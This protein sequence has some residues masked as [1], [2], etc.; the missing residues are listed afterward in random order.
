MNTPFNA[1]TAAELAL[2]TLLTALS[3]G[4]NRNLKAGN[5]LLAKAHADE[6]TIVIT[7]LDGFTDELRAE[8]PALL[9]RYPVEAFRTDVGVWVITPAPHLTPN[10]SV[11]FHLE[12]FEAWTY[13]VGYELPSNFA[14]EQMRQMEYLAQKAPDTYRA[15]N[16]L[17]EADKFQ[18]WNALKLAL[19]TLC[20]GSAA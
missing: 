3:K 13:A 2:Y 20:N 5:I 10:E 9:R 6:N 14:M 8:F 18:Q 11:A 4:Y 15:F 7:E 17:S 12:F 16:T 1:H 19:Q